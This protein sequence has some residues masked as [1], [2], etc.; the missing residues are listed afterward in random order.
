MGSS[1]PLEIVSGVLQRD[2]EYDKD[3]GNSGPVLLN[4]WIYFNLLSNNILLPILVLTILISSQ[5]RRHA[6][7]VNLCLTWILSGVFSLLLFYARQYRDSEP[8]RVLCIAQ[9]SLLFGIIPMWSIAVV[10][11]FYYVYRSF[12]GQSSQTHFRLLTWWFMLS[13]PY[14]FQIA[15]SVAALVISLRH[16]DRVLRRK[17]FFYCGLDSPSLLMART[18]FV[19]ICAGC[20]LIIEALMLRTLYNG[21]VHIRRISPR[22]AGARS[23]R[24]ALPWVSRVLIFGIYVILGLVINLAALTNR[25]SVLPQIYIATAGAVI[26]I[27]FGS[28]TEVLR[29]WF[30][31]RI[32]WREKPR[33][34]HSRPQ[35]SYIPGQQYGDQH[36]FSHDP[37][38][39]HGG[40]GQSYPPRD[41]SRVPSFTL[42]TLFPAFPE[43]VR[44]ATHPVL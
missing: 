40:Y 13:G 6:T 8:P 4:I 35:K 29:V 12:Q 26:F 32:F 15:F 43:P 39:S 42:D 14:F 31:C 21:L 1:V 28:Q 17:G 5:L 36:G 34:V 24:S 3:L 10:A 33:R 25:R 22:T 16:P 30:P 38:D 7:F 2:V 44:V 20:T 37:Y 23:I 19:A 27:V 9:A 11:F 41:F 18:I